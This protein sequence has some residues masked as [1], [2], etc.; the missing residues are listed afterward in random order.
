MAVPY[1]FMV[2]KHKYISTLHSLSL[3][4][5][6]GYSHAPLSEEL[7][8]IN[9]AE[10]IEWENSIK[11]GNSSNTVVLTKRALKDQHFIRILTSAMTAKS[12]VVELD[13]SHNLISDDAI[14]RMQSSLAQNSTIKVLDLSN[15]KITDA[16]LQIFLSILNNNYTLTC[17]N[18]RY[19]PISEEGYKNLLAFLERNK[20]VQLEL[21]KAKL[22]Q[23]TLSALNDTL[24]RPIVN[25]I[26][27][28]VNNAE[29]DEARKKVA[30]LLYP[31]PERI[32]STE[33]Q[34]HSN[35]CS[36]SIAVDYADEAVIFS[37]PMKVKI[38]PDDKTDKPK[39][40]WKCVIL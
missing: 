36:V 23:N 16:G 19:N 5:N 17:V 39:K 28:Y 15:N 8:P 22:Y 24:P 38:P 4:V 18:L 32:P 25:E 20:Q 21:L 1:S 6:S 26:L 11:M 27:E 37:Q 12:K 31:P 7:K 2:M 9:E 10:V 35:D 14:S 34:F 3:G 30:A 33:V 29:I 13:V 40:R